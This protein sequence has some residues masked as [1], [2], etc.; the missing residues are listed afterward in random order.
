MSMR[1][2]PFFEP[3]LV[4]ERQA[5]RLWLDCLK[6][7]DQARDGRL[8]ASVSVNRLHGELSVM[9]DQRGRLVRFWLRT[10][11]GNQLVLVG[12][13]DGLLPLPMNQGAAHV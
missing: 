13:R 1:A 11:I 10:L 9:F 2:A 4:N 7:A 12:N 5:A 3:S 8:Q 6:A